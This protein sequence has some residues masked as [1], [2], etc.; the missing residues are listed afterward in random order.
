MWS[1]W[2]QLQLGYGRWSTPPTAV[3]PQPLLQ[4]VEQLSLS[5][6]WG[7]RRTCQEMIWVQ[8]VR[9]F[10]SWMSN[11]RM[12]SLLLNRWFNFFVIY[13]VTESVCVADR[14]STTAPP[15]TARTTTITTTTTT[16][17][18]PAPPGTPERGNYSVNNSNGTVCLLAQMGLQLNVSYFSLSQN[19]VMWSFVSLIFVINPL[20]SLIWTIIFST[21][22]DGPRCSKPE[23]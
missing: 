4:L 6:I 22:P 21:L 2:C 9:Q 15:T 8:Q 7:W 17:P 1:L 14:A 18:S 23:S 16:T 10:C 13:L 12:F 19:K 11:C 3:W 5:P 20:P